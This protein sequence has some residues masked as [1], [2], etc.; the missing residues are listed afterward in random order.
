[1][2][3]ASLGPGGFRPLHKVTSRLMLLFLLWTAGRSFTH[4]S[5]HPIQS[6]TRDWPNRSHLIKVACRAGVFHLV[7]SLDLMFLF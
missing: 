5:L 3:R 6:R 7:L 2:I 4:R 1:M